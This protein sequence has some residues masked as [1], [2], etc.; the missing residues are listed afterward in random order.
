[1]NPRGKA[2][3]RL[4]IAI[5]REKFRSVGRKSGSSWSGGKKRD[6][7]YPPDRR[8]TH[9]HARDGAIPISSENPPLPR[10]FLH[11]TP[12]RTAR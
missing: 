5:I 4:S 8:S 12:G 11:R 6:G 7:P 3:V 10:K 9:P 2:T 1:M